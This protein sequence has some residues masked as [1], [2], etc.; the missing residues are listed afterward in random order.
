[1]RPI[2]DDAPPIWSAAG[3]VNT[4]IRCFWDRRV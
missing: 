1:M 4:E 2:Y 3:F